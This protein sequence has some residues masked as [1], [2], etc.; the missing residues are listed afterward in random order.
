M[1]AP[2]VATCKKCGNRTLRLEESF[3]KRSGLASVIA[4]TCDSCGDSSSF[5]TSNKVGSAHEV[6]LRFAYAL[7]SIGKGRQSGAVLCALMNMPPPSARI[8]SYNKKILEATRKTAEESTQAAAAEVRK[9]AADEGIALTVDS[10][11]MKRGHSSLFGIVTVISADTGKALDCETES[12][13]CILCAKSQHNEENKHLCEITH[14]GSSGAVKVFKR[15]MDTHALK[16]MVTA[17]LFLAVKESKPYDCDECIG[18]V[19]K[20]MGTRLRNVK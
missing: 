5:C 9:D 20:S 14:T 6:N 3:E 1:M 8:K 17:K 16:V 10:T 19:P 7:R 18:H 15:S 13:F 4:A 12:K 2:F 11:W